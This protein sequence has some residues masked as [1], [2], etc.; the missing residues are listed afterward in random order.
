[1]VLDEAVVL[2]VEVQLALRV[3]RGGCSIKRKTEHPVQ[4]REKII[5]GGPVVRLRG[6]DVRASGLRRALRRNLRHLAPSVRG[7]TG[8]G[9][10]VPT[11]GVGSDNPL[12][13]ATRIGRPSSGCSTANV[14]L[15][16]YVTMHYLQRLSAGKDRI[17][18]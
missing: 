17:E 11:P 14:Y 4:L 13:S 5:R 1:P 12:W 10:F 6:E 2:E 18:E 15:T 16:H 7:A 8:V 9:D 3:L